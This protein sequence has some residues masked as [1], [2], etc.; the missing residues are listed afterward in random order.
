MNW[1]LLSG[2]Y[3]AAGL[4]FAWLWTWWDLHDTTVVERVLMDGTS[5]HRADDDEDHREHVAALGLAFGLVWPLSVLFML[6]IMVPVW[7]AKTVPVAADKVA[8]E[9]NELE[10][11]RKMAAELGIDP[12]CVDKDGAA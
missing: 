12:I 3:V 9:K 5:I 7:L 11:Y 10:R 1:W 2:A 8:A 6:A 4:G